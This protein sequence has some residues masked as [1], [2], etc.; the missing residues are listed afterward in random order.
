MQRDLARTGSW[1][2]SRRFV[3]RHGRVNALLFALGVLVLVLACVRQG[4]PAFNPESLWL[5]DLWVATL[6]KR[7]SLWELGRLHAPV[8]YGF[9]A[10]E[11]L[12]RAGFG[13]GHIQL[14]AAP[15][16]L[17]L[18][19]IAGLGWLTVELTRNVG[20]GLT[21]AAGLALQNELAQQALRIKHY[22][23]DAAISVGLLA[24]ALRFLRQPH[25]RRLVPLALASL[26]ALPC[27]FPSAFVGP[28]LMSLCGLF[29]AYDQR[30]ANPREAMQTLALMAAS[31]LLVLGFIALLVGQK[32]T[33]ALQAFWSAYYPPIQGAGK[34]A[35]FFCT[36]PG[37]DFLTGAFAPVPW[38]ATLVPVGV[39][40]LLSTRWTRPL[41]VFALVLHAAVLASSL[42]HLYPL[43]VPRLDAYVRPI[44]VLL[45]V[46]ALARVRVLHR[47][48]IAV[49]CVAVLVGVRQLAA[50]PVSYIPAA[51]KPLARHIVRWI[52]DSR[53]GLVL[54]PWA[55][56]AFAYYTDEPVELVPVTDSTNGFFAIPKRPHRWVLRETWHG[57]FFSDYARDA[58]AF[59]DQLATLFAAPPPRLAFYGGYGDDADYRA[60]LSQ[61]HNHG[62]VTLQGHARFGAI[63]AL[64][65]YR[66]AAR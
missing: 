64:L 57:V 31:N 7:A 49:A 17:R 4:L 8:P 24:L 22:T 29:H 66:P 6:V 52:A 34:F 56:W 12:V 11:K 50:Q 5:D 25:C 42:L 9:V 21:A 46:V 59:A 2:F 48:S 55:N 36:G 45:A 60:I 41:G 19:S 30:K 47:L 33:P 35:S 14:Q 53:T 15:F 1:R 13:D 65:E 61:F 43:G 26:L 38:L 44:Q 62:Y 32:A 54:F 58:A 16:L 40:I 63:A 20:L 10:L 23:L 51:E 37:R 39:L 18:A 3:R 27:S 28:V